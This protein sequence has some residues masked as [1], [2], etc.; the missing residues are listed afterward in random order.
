[1]EIVNRFQEHNIVKKASDCK[2][3]VKS[4]TYKTDAIF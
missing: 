2:D 1:M 3:D 4:V